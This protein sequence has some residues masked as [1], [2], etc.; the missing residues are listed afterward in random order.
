VEGVV[1]RSG[2]ATLKSQFKMSEAATWVE[3]APANQGD[4]K[5]L[6]VRHFLLFAV[7]SLVSG[8]TLSSWMYYEGARSLPKLSTP[9]K[10]REE[11][12]RLA[13]EAVLLRHFDIL[14]HRI[15]V[16]IAVGGAGCLG[17]MGTGLA[18]WSRSWLK[19]LKVKDEEGRKAMGIL[20]IK[21][22]EAIN[23]Q[24][25]LLI[26]HGDIEAEAQ[27]LGYVNEKLR[28]EMEQ[29]KRT[30]KSL[31]QRR[32][33]LESSKT[34]LE[35]H[36]QER[37]GELQKL[38]RRYELILN[39]AGEGICGLDADGKATFL[40]P[41][42]A[43]ITGWQVHELIGK[44]EEEIFG[45]NGENGDSSGEKHFGER[46]FSRKDGSSLPVEYIRTPIEENG[47]TIG[48]VVVFKDITERKRVED[49][50]SQKAAEL[51]RSNA[52]LEQFAFVASHDLQEPL[53]KIQAFG[54]RLKL[55]VQ[56]ELAPEAR[57][58]LERMQSASARMRT[59]INDLLTFSRVIRRTEP[60]VAVDLGTVT[61]GVLSD[62]EVR[63][64]K[65]GAQ[66]EI[67][68]L[69]IIEADPMQMQQLVLNLVGNAL[70]F[71]P[72]GAKPIVRI[73]SRVF[74]ALSGEEYCEI[75]FQDN[76]IGFDEKYMDKIFAVFQRLHGRNEYEG[77]GVGLAVCRRITDRHHGTITAKSQL[78]HG[79]TFIVTLPTRQAAEKA[80]T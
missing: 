35:L 11:Q 25:A 9:T 14:V 30:E 54:D 52:E 18:L 64:E 45:R 27:R 12:I 72:P 8:I 51:A 28:A 3:S 36:V 76:G 74:T 75:H 40:N 15:M 66:I 34:V 39:S 22:T 20:H 70:K 23:A 26:K 32:Q 62:L 60:F 78:G 4:V 17:G 69:P 2:V 71:Q 55:K 48:T 37:T 57:E 43:R 5:P 50:I 29:L 42:V 38:Q 63:I 73:A 77:T 16:P 47:R 1:G 7:L 58:Y 21:L 49:A 59:L 56:G 61:K 13:Q 31:S 80:S 24:Q 53:R 41:A 10:G 44:T 79:A 67:G 65:S 6:V 19:R 33:E 46:V 68:D